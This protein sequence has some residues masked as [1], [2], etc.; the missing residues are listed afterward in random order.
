VQLAVES[1]SLVEGNNVK[2][3]EDLIIARMRQLDERVTMEDIAARNL[4]RIRTQNKAYF[5]AAARLRPEDHEIHTGDFVLVFRPAMLQKMKS[6][7]LKLDERWQGPYRVR[8]KPLDSTFYL[9]DKLDGTPLKRKYA[10]DQVK[11]YFP[12]MPGGQQTLDHLGNANI[13]EDDTADEVA[14]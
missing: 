10:G 14:G 3:H 8:E 4:R 5:D 6:C 7:D 2:S 11:K 1:W 9:L 12:R 13:N